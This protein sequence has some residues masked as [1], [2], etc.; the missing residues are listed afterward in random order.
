MHQNPFFLWLLLLIALNTHG[1][2]DLNGDGLSDIWQIHYGATQVDPLI[3]SDG[4]GLLNQEECIAGTDPFDAQSTLLL[5][6]L[7]TTGAS[8]RIDWLS[9]QHIGYELQASTNLASNL[10]FTISLPGESG[11]NGTA[12]RFI[13]NTNVQALRVI[14][15]DSDKDRDGLN[16][17][18]EA[19]LQASDLQRDSQAAGTSDYVTLVNQLTSG[20]VVNLGGTPVQTAKP[21]LQQA[22]RFLSA[23]TFG[24][25]YEELQLV[26]N[27]GYEAWIDQQIAITPSYHHQILSEI[28]V[29]E[30]GFDDDFPNGLWRTFAWW[31]AALVKPDALRQRV[32]MALSEIFV[33]S[34]IGSDLLEDSS[35][36]FAHYYDILVRNAFG[37]FKTLLTEITYH[38][39]MGVYLSH[40]WN[41]R[42]DPSLNRFPDENYAREIMQLFSIGLYELHQDGTRK[43]DANG[44][45]IPTYTNAEITEFAKIFTGFG[46]PNEPVFGGDETFGDVE[47]S[48]MI[49]IAA[50]HEPGPKYLLNGMVVPDGQTPEKD[51]ADAMQ[52]LFDHPNAGPFIAYRLIQ[53]L[54]TSNPSPGYVYRVAGAFNDNGS[55]VRG[56]LGAVVKA[57]LM[58]PE[59]L[60]LSRKDRNDYGKVKEPYLRYVQLVRTF[61]A[62]SSN[63]RIYHIDYDAFEAF[64]QAPLMS[65]SVFNF[66]QPEYSP[67][68]SISQAGLAA[69]EFQIM[70]DNRLISSINLLSYMIYEQEFFNYPLTVGDPQ[71]EPDDY[72]HV[73]TRP[74]NLDFTDEMAL[75]NNPAALVDR[76]DLL[77]THG[78]MSAQTKAT[79]IK[80]MN[81]FRNEGADDRDVFGTALWLVMISPDYTI[82][83]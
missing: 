50:E 63:G 24:S 33:V 51:V 45:D 42:S 31:E 48:P 13:T 1:E 66:F 49:L 64:G 5:Q 53:R 43:K 80:A 57:I 29:L 79:I 15:R 39:V 61:D 19:F 72:F 44:N 32:A 3:D 62:S 6:G 18:E 16:A 20:S 54:T 9:Q 71:E 12:S 14:A 22:A 75:I 30:S 11:I 69:P 76:L 35:Y 28:K 81:D 82:R 74:V 47:T 65:P 8:N 68:G 67:Q 2:I 73:H 52:N 36:H 70:T 38:P 34:P 58:D 26:T 4:D 41:R 60:N 27:I 56:D 17:F 78:S 83:K 46:L 21:S 10:W 77:L 25:P 23:A 40:L 55:G 7:G 59:N 37:N